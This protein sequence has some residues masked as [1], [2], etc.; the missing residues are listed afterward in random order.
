VK[1]KK[2]GEAFVLVSSRIKAHPRRHEG[3]AAQVD[4]VAMTKC[5]VLA[6]SRF[7]H[8]AHHML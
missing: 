5:C 4:G 1:R 3:L 8:A 7:Q 2:G 6:A